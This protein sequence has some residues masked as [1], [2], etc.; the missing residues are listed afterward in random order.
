MIIIFFFFLLLLLLLTNICPS[1]SLLRRFINLQ[2]E[3]EEKF[4]EITLVGCTNLESF[5]SKPVE[6]ANVE[7]IIGSG[8]TDMN[9]DKV[10]TK[11]SK[12][13][14]KANPNFLER[15]V[16][17]CML[18]K[19]KI[20]W[21]SFPL[22]ANLYDNRH[23]GTGSSKPLI[24]QCKIAL[25]TDVIKVDRVDEWSEA[26]EGMRE[27]QRRSPR[28]KMRNELWEGDLDDEGQSTYFVS[29]KDRFKLGRPILKGSLEEI[30]PEPSFKEYNFLR[31]RGLT[32]NRVGAMKS[33]IKFMASSDAPPSLNTKYFDLKTLFKKQ[34]KRYIVR[35]YVLH[36]WDLPSSGHDDVTGRAKK[37]RPYLKV[38]LGSDNVAISDINDYNVGAE[39]KRGAD[40]RAKADQTPTKANQTLKRG[41]PEIEHNNAFGFYK[42]FELTTT[43]PSNSKGGNNL[44]ISVMNH[45]SHDDDEVIGSTSIDILDRFYNARWQELGRENRVDLSN[46]GMQGGAFSG[47][48]FPHNSFPHSDLDKIVHKFSQRGLSRLGIG[49][50]KNIA[51]AA[52]DMPIEQPPN[53]QPPNEQQPNEQPKFKEGQCSARVRCFLSSSAC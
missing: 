19:N 52:E 9:S 46:K 15:S 21:D 16:L 50:D 37:P 32:Y 44:E 18:P 30:L 11:G 29:T 14:T 35:I 47:N 41:R 6:F 8:T 20:F 45:K 38:S 7:F 43:L 31:D 33:R 10:V 27:L 36:C 51:E 34:A 17:K 39:K 22:I 25:D 4:I 26:S 28:L 1:F 48:F 13:P 42:R 24:G 12:K 3:F 53:E 23:I 49:G 40:V 5:N 2:P